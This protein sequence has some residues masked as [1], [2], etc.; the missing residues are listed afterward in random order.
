MAFDV[1]S[2]HLI[3]GQQTIWTRNE[4]ATHVILCV[5]ADA[6]FDRLNDQFWV[7]SAAREMQLCLL[8][9]LCT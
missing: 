9:N 2:K 4:G 5:N 1:T 8:A 7:S 6:L 3:T